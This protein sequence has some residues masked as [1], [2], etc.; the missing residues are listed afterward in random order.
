MYS[1]VET[2]TPP[3]RAAIDPRRLALLVV[4]YVCFA[5]G[6]IG[7]FLPVLPTTVFW[8]MAALCFART[9]PTMYRRIVDRPG[10]GPVISDF[11]RHGV[12]GPRNKVIAIAGM[13]A[14]SAVILFTANGTFVT[15]VTIVGI[16]SGALYV[17]TRPS[18]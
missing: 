10:V 9:S 12:I 16:A 6:F 11:V 2:R 3:R 18:R 1:V 13:G 4:G 15:A 17:L 14:A 5:T 8:I 7:L